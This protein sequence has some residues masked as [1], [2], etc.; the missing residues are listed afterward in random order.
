MKITIGAAYKSPVCKSRIK[1]MYI[2]GVFYSR[3]IMV[4]RFFIP[5]EDYPEFEMETRNSK[6]KDKDILE[7]N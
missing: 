6:N 3:E 1:H 4:S 7:R 5:T 2:M